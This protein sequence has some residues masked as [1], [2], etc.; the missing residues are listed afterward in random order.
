MRA[1]V[2][3]CM[4]LLLSAVFFIPYASNF[5]MISYIAIFYTSFLY[6]AIK[7]PEYFGMLIISA[8]LL[9]V[10]GQLAYLVAPAVGQFIYDSGVIPMI[11]WCQH[12]ILYRTNVVSGKSVTL[13][14]DFVG[15]R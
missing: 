3:A 11:T 15:H 12:S 8:L 9:H 6:H 7:T 2:D 1:G 5:Y 10:F 4:C 14:D 13:R